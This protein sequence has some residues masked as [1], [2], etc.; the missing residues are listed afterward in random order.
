[1]S[2]QAGLYQ[3]VS[4]VASHL[5]YLSQPQ[6]TVLGFW[7]FGMLALGSCGITS[8]AALLA[9]LLEQKENTVRQR[10]R[11]WYYEA[12]QKRGTQRREIDV[13]ACFAPLLQ[14]VLASWPSDECRLALALDATT[15]GQRFTVLA[16]CVLYRGCAIPV[17]WQIVSGTQP[18][19]WRPHWLKLFSLLGGAL[20]ASWT[21]IVLA[22]RGLYAPW[23][24]RHIVRLGWH[25]FFRINRG[26]KVRL[27]MGGYWRSLNHLVPAPGA[28]WAG[29]VRCFKNQ[30]LDCTLLA[31]WE[32]QYADP[33]LI[34]TNLVPAAGDACWYALRAWIECEFK[35][36]KAGGWQWQHTRVTDP[37]RA[38]RFW[39][40]IAVATLW[41]VNVGGAEDAALPVSS[42]A[43][44]PPN[45]VARQGPR[46]KTGHRQLSCLRRGW[47][48]V[49]AMLL[50]GVSIRLNP[51]L[52]EPWPNSH[53]AKIHLE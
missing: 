18:G 42:F 41:A 34:V 48:C 7:T 26:G 27:A 21:V 29:Q 52:P 44:L 22:D 35:D 46:P 53:A 51:F 23:L 5:S 39:L 6:A 15:L 37:D 31:R 40:I 30:P 1:M 43:A 13:T 32:L 9:E 36:A 8:V 24:F 28:S 11:E 12:D 49:L 4:T 19:A 50:R 25:P 45:H 3:W 14:W 16:V 38:T 20:P 2:R 47:I 17:A 33:W 10:L